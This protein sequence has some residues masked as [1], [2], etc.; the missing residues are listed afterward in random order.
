M[1]GCEPPTDPSS[2]GQPFVEGIALPKP[3]IASA[4]D[5]AQNTVRF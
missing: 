5:R 2:A 3:N 1:E 4:S